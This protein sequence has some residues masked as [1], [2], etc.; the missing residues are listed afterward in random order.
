[1]VDPVT[2]AGC[3]P[4]T[5]LVIAHPGH[6][7]RVFHWMERTRPLVCI[8]TDGSGATERSRVESTRCVVARTG[9]RMG[10]WQGRVRDS[11]V[12]QWLLSGAH[13]RFLRLLNELVDILISRGI[14]VVAADAA[15]GFNPSHDVCRLLVNAAVARLSSVERV[16]ENYEFALERSPAAATGRAPG[17]VC[18]TL[19]DLALHRKL[20]AAGGYVELKP[21]VARALAAHGRDA[22]RTECLVPVTEPFDLSAQYSGPPMYERHG[23]DRVAAGVYSTAITFIDHMVPLVQAL[24]ATA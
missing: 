4:T 19:D 16:A 10:P 2:A 11:D 7:L 20:E 22:F 23:A 3:E 14:R 8:L 6:E 5:A 15:E 18:L 13:D 21:E 12:Y 9:A 17:Q 24:D 1:M